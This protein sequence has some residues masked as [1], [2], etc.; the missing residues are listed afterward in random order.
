[1]KRILVLLAALLIAAPAFA[2]NQGNGFSIP[3]EAGNIPQTWGVL[4]SN[5]TALSSTAV[6]QFEPISAFAAAPQATAVLAQQPLANGGF[7]R[8]LNCVAGAVEGS[9]NTVTVTVVINGTSVAAP[10]CVITGATQ[11][12]CQAPGPWFVAPAVAGSSTVA[13]SVTQVAYQTA[14]SGSFTGQTLACTV[15]YTNP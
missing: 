9:G 3:G 8:N 4:T 7:L 11:L 1:M 13:G 5:V 6:T 12:E 10:T 14:L 15:E 2:Q